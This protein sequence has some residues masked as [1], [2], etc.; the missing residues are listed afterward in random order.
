MKLLKQILSIT[1]VALLALTIAGC[2]HSGSSIPQESVPQTSYTSSV[3]IDVPIHDTATHTLDTNM[4]AAIVSA[5]GNVVEEFVITL[6]AAIYEHDT[7][8]DTIHIEVK[9]LSDFRYTLGSF[10]DIAY[11]DHEIAGLPYYCGQTFGLDKAEGFSVPAVYALDVDAA[12]IIIQW[13]N[14][15]NYYL[16]ASVNSSV[17]PVEIMEHFEQFQS[18][19]SYS[20]QNNAS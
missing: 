9:P 13:R 8:R 2:E 5:E 20:N 10:K 7:E 6:Q 12:Y 15:S 18:L 14:Y 3:P 16:V 19:Y 4:H 11:L 1:W 17:S